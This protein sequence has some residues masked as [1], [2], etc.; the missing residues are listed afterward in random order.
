M[1]WDGYEGG[2]IASRLAI[3]AAKRYIEEHFEEIQHDNKEEI[4]KVI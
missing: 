1:E 3:N 4:L 2:E